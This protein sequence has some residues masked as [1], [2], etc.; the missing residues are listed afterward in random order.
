MSTCPGFAEERVLD[1]LRAQLHVPCRLAGLIRDQPSIQ[2]REQVLPR[3]VI[4]LLTSQPQPRLMSFTCSGCGHGQQQRLIPQGA[5]KCKIK[6]LGLGRASLFCPYWVGRPEA[7]G[8][9][10][11][12]VPSSEPQKPGTRASSG[13]PV[14]RDP[15]NRPHLPTLCTRG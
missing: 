6:V 1:C 4:A 12:S 14:R 9:E 7:Q 3:N 13:G 11:D 5:G 15:P 10:T 8:L 2:P